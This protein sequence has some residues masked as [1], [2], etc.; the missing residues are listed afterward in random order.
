MQNTSLEY[1]YVHGSLILRPGISYQ[2]SVY[3]DGKWVDATLKNGF[4]NGSRDLNSLAYYLRADYKAFDKL[5]FVAAIRGDKYNIPDETK[6]TYQLITT[7][8]INENNLVRAGYSQANRGA[9]LAESYANM[10]WEIIPDF[11]VIQLQKNKDLTLPKINMLEVGYR[12]KIGKNILVELEAFHTIFNKLTAFMPDAM[13]LDFDFLPLK[14]GQ[15]PNTLPSRIIGHGQFQNVELKSVQDGLTVDISVVANRNL[16]FKLFGTVQKSTLKNYYDKTVNDDYYSLQYA[17]GAKYMMDVFRIMRGETNLMPDPGNIKSYKAE[18][19]TFRDSSNKTMTNK[20]TPS[21]YGG[22]S[23]DYSYNKKLHFNTS[24]YFFTEQTLLHSKINDIGKYRPEYVV[25]PGAY[26]PDL[27][28]DAYT[29]EPKAVLNLKVSY[30]FWKE[31]NI[32]VNAR[33]LLNSKSKEFAFMDEVR[34]LYMAGIN[35]NF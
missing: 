35:F 25:N 31:N 20:A 3:N 8:N 22:F 26:N 23:A 7:Y 32:F 9:F 2:S 14:T 27:Y 30:K 21:F 34:G 33:N 11:Y 13:T 18:Y 1:E 17:A 5:R 12:T 24:L 15:A 28:R 29:V 4:L 19:T 6:L 16:Y 10:D